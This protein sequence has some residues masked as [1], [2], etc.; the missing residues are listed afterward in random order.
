MED[1]M[2]SAV[3]VLSCLVMT[4]YFTEGQSYFHIY[5]VTSEVI[6]EYFL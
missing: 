6:K 1:I 3:K 4:W 5:N 2:Y